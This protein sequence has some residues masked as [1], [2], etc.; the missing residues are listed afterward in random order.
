MPYIATLTAINSR[1]DSAGNCYWAFRFVHHATGETIE[2]KIS[3]GQ[4]NI[5][6]IM[7][8]MFGADGWNREIAFNTEELKIREFDRLTKDWPY[9][10]CTSADLRQYITD[11]IPPF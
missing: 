8:G 1:Q 9:A 10:G 3:G 4:S 6:G 2:A 7:H 11:R 5:Y